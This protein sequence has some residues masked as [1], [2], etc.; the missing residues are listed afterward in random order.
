MYHKNESRSHVPLATRQKHFIEGLDVWLTQ[1]SYFQYFD[2]CLLF[3]LITSKQFK[4][5]SIAKKLYVEL[6]EYQR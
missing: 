3:I 4:A 5:T 6:F 1:L 2:V